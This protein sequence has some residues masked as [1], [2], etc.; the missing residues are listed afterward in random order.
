MNVLREPVAVRRPSRFAA[1]RRFV[2]GAPAA[3]KNRIT[4]RPENTPQLATSPARAA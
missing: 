1:R 4:G 3:R 2:M